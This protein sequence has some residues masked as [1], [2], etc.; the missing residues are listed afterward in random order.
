MACILGGCFSSFGV[1]TGD[2]RHGRGLHQHLPLDVRFSHARLQIWRPL[3]WRR[4]AASLQR[5]IHSS[6][7][8]SEWC[9]ISTPA[10]PSKAAEIAALNGG[11]IGVYNPTLP[12]LFLLFAD[13]LRLAQELALRR[14]Q[15]RTA[16]LEKATAL[17]SARPAQ[18]PVSLVCAVFSAATTTVVG[19]P[20]VPCAELYWFVEGSGIV[21][22]LP[23]APAC[24]GALFASISGV[25]WQH[26]P[27]R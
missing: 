1:R 6:T 27:V 14:R 21:R 18:V 9:R 3:L 8:A 16:A 20:G 25:A 7:S 12:P 17:M 24:L 15:C 22:R 23:S 2:A 19:F 5:G 10:L 26:R 13:M 4:S 11:E